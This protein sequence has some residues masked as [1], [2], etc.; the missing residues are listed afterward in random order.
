VVAGTSSY[1]CPFQTPVSTALR[2]FWKN[3]RHNPTLPPRP[4]GAHAFQVLSSNV[5]H[6]LWKKVAR[7]VVFSI[8]RFEQTVVHMASNLNRWVR[9]TLGSQQH[10]H[11]SSPAVSLEAIREDSHV[12]LEP[13]SFLNINGSSPHSANT[14]IHNT[15]SLDDN[16]DP[17]SQEASSSSRDTPTPTPGVAEPWMVREG[18]AVIQKEN[19]KDDRCV[20][21]ILRNIT[22]PEAVDTAIR[23]A[24]T[25]RWFEDGVDVEPPYNIIVSLFHTCLDSTGTVYPGLRDRAYHS[26]QAIL[27]IH[28]RAVCVAGEFASRFPLPSMESRAPYDLDLRSL[29]RI[30]DIIRSSELSPHMSI[31]AESNSPTH[32]RWA[33]HTI[34]H[35]CWTKQRNTD[36]LGPISS[37]SDIVGAHWDT[38][39]L[40][41]TLDLLLVW[42]IQLGCPVEEEMLKVEDKTYVIPCFSFCITHITVYQRGGLHSI[43]PRDS[44]SLPRLSPTSRTPPRRPARVNQM[45]QPPQPLEEDGV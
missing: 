29:L 9:I 1:A 14:S 40:D 3:F 31:F 20:S 43:L 33:S 42:S 45:E 12:S 37:G 34:L 15:N 8:L 10:V 32:V 28:V 41:A 27:W 21:W 39:P 2:G 36:A 25:V 30:Y 19:A 7:R 26:V 17:L 22:D 13:S 4:V 23:F 16:A 38:I 6:P 5:L 18:L 35:F 24:C 11:H 44:R